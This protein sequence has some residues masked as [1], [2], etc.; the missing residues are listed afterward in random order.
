MYI[1]YLY[2]YHF[3]SDCWYTVYSILFVCNIVR[4]VLYINIYISL[5]PS[6]HLYLPLL[7][8]PLL[9]PFRSLCM[10]ICM[11]VAHERVCGEVRTRQRE[12][13]QTGEYIHHILYYT[14]CTI[15]YSIYCINSILY[16]ISISHY[17]NTAYAMYFRPKV[18]KRPSIRCS[19]QAS[20]IES[21]KNES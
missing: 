12:D 17:F 2:H 14:T 8:S 18:K 4:L 15:H 9:F 6:L 16:H 1:T 21:N 3:H 7:K 13:G 5:S 11:C 20:P 10:Y 19:S